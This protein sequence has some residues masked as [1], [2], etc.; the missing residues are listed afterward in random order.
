[1]LWTDAYTTELIDF[2]LKANPWEHHGKHEASTKAWDAVAAHLTDKCQTIGKVTG[3]QCR[4]KLN[5]LC[6]QTLE[7]NGRVQLIAPSEQDQVKLD[8]CAEVPLHGYHCC[9]Y[10][11]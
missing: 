9:Y 6:R 11:S 8:K 4:D 10:V 3:D 1:M 2:S 5:K 7:R